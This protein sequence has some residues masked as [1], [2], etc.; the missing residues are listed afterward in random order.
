MTIWTAAQAIH[1]AI[2]NPCPALRIDDYRALVDV[3]HASL[4]TR[5]LA[6]AVSTGQWMTYEQTVEYALA[7]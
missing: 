5:E 1:T 2:G 3:A 7:D 4:D 6:A